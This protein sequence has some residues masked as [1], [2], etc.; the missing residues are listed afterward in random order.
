M[1]LRQL[2]QLQLLRQLQTKIKGRIDDL[3]QAV[4]LRLGGDDDTVLGKQPLQIVHGDLLTGDGALADAG[5]HGVGEIQADIDLLAGFGIAHTGTS[6]V[7]YILDFAV[8]DGT[9]CSVSTVPHS[10]ANCNKKLYQVH[11]IYTKKPVICRKS[12]VSSF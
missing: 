1:L 3:Q 7:A 6:Y 12:P 10:H 8:R 4:L 2:E 5:E 11:S 9:F